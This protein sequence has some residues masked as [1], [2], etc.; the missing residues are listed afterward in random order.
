[1]KNKQFPTVGPQ[2]E[3]S[4]DQRPR[5][6]G[7]A[8]LRYERIESFANPALKLLRS[9]DQKKARAESGLFLCEGARHASEALAQG[10]RLPLVLVAETAMDRP[11]VQK[12]A[13]D[14]A[15]RGGRVLT[16]P[17][18]VME[19][20]AHRDNAQTVIAACEMETS[21]LAD[22]N[23][24][25]HWGLLALYEVRDPGNLGTLLRSADAVGVAGVVLLERCCDPFSVEATRASMGS[26]FSV[27]VVKAS[28]AAFDAWRRSKNLALRAAS[29]RAN[30]V[31]AE[32]APAEQA[33]A[34][35]RKVCVLMGNEQAGLPEAVE[36]ACDDLVRLPM[37][38]E[39][40]DSLN[41]ASAGA[42]M[43]YQAWQEAGYAG[44]R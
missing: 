14:V 7:A 40:P 36:A 19:K 9:L 22:L 6:G 16:A 38:A 11:Y 17:D 35:C 41:V 8:A 21:E 27:M 44:A 5:F 37:R 42:V 30:T 25:A 13:E 15:G 29:L 12:L 31:M 2:S 18:R 34:R 24:G 10:W 23:V 4:R 20:V 26:L 43:L 28:F 32:E 39:G 1:M 3:I 33:S